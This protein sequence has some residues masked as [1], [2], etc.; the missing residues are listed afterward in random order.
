MKFGSWKYTRNLPYLLTCTH[1]AAQKKIPFPLPLPL[2]RPLPEL[3][4]KR[5]LCR[6]QKG[7]FVPH[8]FFKTRGR[9]GRKRRKEKG[10]YNAVLRRAR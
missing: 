2:L 9:G 4:W 7:R 8:N 6:V 5:A 1:A 10:P 3:S